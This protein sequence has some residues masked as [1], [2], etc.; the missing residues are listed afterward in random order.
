MTTRWIPTSAAVYGA[1]RSFHHANMQVFGTVT[2]LGEYSDHEHIMTEWGLPGA[3]YPLVKVDSKGG[4]ASYW[5]AVITKDD[6]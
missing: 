6:E 1:I 2:D 4:I 3:D 5:I